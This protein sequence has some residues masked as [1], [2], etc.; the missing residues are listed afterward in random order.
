MDKIKKKIPKIFYVVMILIPVFFF[1]L[2]ETGLRIFN[3]GRNLDA[4]ITLSEDYDDLLFVNP[5]IPFRYV[6][7]MTTPPAVTLDAFKKIKTDSTYRI[8]VMGGS[9]TAGFPYAYNITFPKYLQRKLTLL[10]PG[11]NIEVIN[12][13]I[14]AHNSY[15]I[16]DLA[17]EVLEQEPDL[18]LVYA[19]HNEYYGI[20]GV[21]STASYGSSRFISNIMI[22]L[23]KLKTFQLLANFI[24]W[25]GSSLSNDSHG[26]NNET[27]MSRMIGDNEILYN[28]EVYYQGISQFEAN[29]KEFLDKMNEKGVNT[30]LGTLS[31]N[32]LQKPFVSISKDENKSADSLYSLGLDYLDSNNFQKAS[33]LFFEAKEYDALR[34]RAPQKINDVIIDLGVTYNFPVV[35]IDSAFSANSPNG[36]VGYDLMVDHLHPNI[37]GYNLIGENFFQCMYDHKLLPDKSTITKPEIEKTDS[38][39]AEQF[40]YTALD[41][42]IS[43]LRIKKLLNSYPFVPKNENETSRIIYKADN[44]IDTIAV[45]MLNKEISWRSAHQEVAQYYFVKGMFNNFIQEMNA[46]IQYQPYVEIAYFFTISRLLNVKLYD[47]AMVFLNKFHKLR[48]SDYTYKWLG[49]INLING[50]VLEAINYLNKSI[51]LNDTD[52]QVYYNLAG[53]FYKSGQIEQALD[54]IKTSLN[55]DP[56][57]NQAIQFYQS[58]SS[59]YKN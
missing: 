18:I 28:S 14:T 4:F 17:D 40:P 54:A 3:Y 49:S 9:S 41:S 37:R 30:I 10:Y 32:H 39:L 42:T 45:K 58:L 11:Y 21:G 7:N 6:T 8:F 59:R 23:N 55:I 22:Q 1:I 35:K 46:I 26:V 52:S 16:T 25:T 48:P 20:L 5:D 24:G 57:N 51:E 56:D 44:F 2:L 43:K 12:L 19:G 50:N 53:A 47:E 29:M 27:L 33:K 34:F 36:I 13:G 15:T 38:I 31:S